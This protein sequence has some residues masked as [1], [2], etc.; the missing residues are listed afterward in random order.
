[1]Q[2]P[3]YK[4][5]FIYLCTYTNMFSYMRNSMQIYTYMSF[6]FSDRWGAGCR[7]FCPAFLTSSA[8]QNTYWGASIRWTFQNSYKDLGVL[9]NSACH[10]V[11]A[12]NFVVSPQKKRW[13]V[14][15]TWVSCFSPPWFRKS[16][17]FFNST[18]LCP[19][20]QDDRRGENARHWG[21]KKNR[22]VSTAD[23]KK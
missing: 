9:S 17:C 23:I 7:R 20:V 12:V 10:E 2:K 15:K 5:S 3:I 19:Q 14:K 16:S 18:D 11:K 4:C 13:F 1:M 6:H 8:L 22:L 21:T